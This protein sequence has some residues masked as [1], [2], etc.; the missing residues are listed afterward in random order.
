[1][2][3]A[4]KLTLKEEIAA[5]APSTDAL[6]EAAAELEPDDKTKQAFAL[7]LAAARI[8]KTEG[9]K[10]SLQ[11]VLAALDVAGTMMKEG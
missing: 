7:L 6:L 5:V 3:G 9:L 1:M 8:V 11:H 2:F 4:A 10:V